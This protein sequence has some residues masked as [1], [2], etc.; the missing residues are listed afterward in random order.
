[1][2]GQS[3]T[4]KKTV[5]IWCAGE[6]VPAVVSEEVKEWASQTHDGLGRFFPFIFQR[7]T[8]DRP[9][10]QWLVNVRVGEQMLGSV[11]HGTVPRVGEFLFGTGQEDTSQY[12]HPSRVVRW[13]GRS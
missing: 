5:W 11:G 9:T 13:Q 2:E 8:L 4:N 1:M 10:R 7:H 12:P 6:E 3:R